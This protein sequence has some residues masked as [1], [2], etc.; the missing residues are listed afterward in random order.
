MELTVDIKVYSIRKDI[1][2]LM[3]Q[4]HGP[5][6]G[7]VWRNE[8]IERYQDLIDIKFGN[9]VLTAIKERTV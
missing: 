4:I 6:L 7:Q 1:D 8:D 3:D 5:G 2:L 9:G